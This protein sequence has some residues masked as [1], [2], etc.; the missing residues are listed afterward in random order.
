MYKR[1]IMAVL[2][3][4][5]TYA[6][7]RVL[8]TLGMGIITY[9]GL[10]ALLGYATDQIKGALGYLPDLALNLMGLAQMDIAINIILS[11]YS[12]NLGMMALQRLRIL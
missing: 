1:M 3:L 4:I 10:D 7:V 11:A 5:V 9:I 2:P 8:Y 6:L 12:V